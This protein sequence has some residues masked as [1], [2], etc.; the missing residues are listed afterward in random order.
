MS[1][2]N[3]LILGICAMSMGGCVTFDKAA[4]KLGVNFWSQKDKKA[5]C[6]PMVSL[7]EEIHCVG[8]PLE[9]PSGDEVLKL[10]GRYTVQNGVMIGAIQATP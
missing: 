4:T 1:L 9:K 3:I 2:R 6:K 8:L 7:N 5:P 10:R